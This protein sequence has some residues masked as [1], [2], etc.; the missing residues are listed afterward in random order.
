MAALGVGRLPVVAD[1]DP[2][3]LEGMFRREDAVSAYHLALT[4][5]TDVELH[6]ARLAQRTDPGAGYYD[7]RVPPGSMADG[8]AIREVSWPEES[9]LVSVRRDRG[10]IVPGGDTILL[11][12]DVVTAFGTATSKSKMIERLNAGAMEATAEIFLD[13]I[14]AEGRLRDLEDSGD[15]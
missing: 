10:V 12:G 4:A 6:R 5:A 8:R 3:R 15:G 11:R 9:T 1:D 2:Q 7:F 14:E 13:E